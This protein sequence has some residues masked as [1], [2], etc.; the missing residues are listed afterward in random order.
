[1][2]TIDADDKSDEDYDVIEISVVV[3]LERPNLKSQ[4]W[5]SKLLVI[6]R[7]YN[8]FLSWF[9]NIVNEMYP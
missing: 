3:F 2:I 7:I 5:S 8:K 9:Q 4:Q 6:S 1:M